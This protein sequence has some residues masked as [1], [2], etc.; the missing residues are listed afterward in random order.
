MR[1]TR[2]DLTPDQVVEAER[3]FEAL[4]QAT[5]DEQW[6]IA[7]LLASR[8]DGQIFCATEY[9]VRDLTHRIGDKAIEAALRGRKK[10]GTSAPA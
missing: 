6:Q 7:Q 10:G 3:I 4:R 2:T 1:T 8:P 5:E 9:Q